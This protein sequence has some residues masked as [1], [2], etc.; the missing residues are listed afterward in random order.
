MH[1]VL[2]EAVSGLND[3]EI[4]RRVL[5]GET[6]LFELIV[7]RYNQRLFRTTRAILRD[8][9]A[10]EDAM[11]EAYLRAFA[12]L[13]QFAGEAKFS[14]WLTKIAVYEALGR[15]RKAKFEEE[16]DEAMDAE[17]NPERAAYGRELQSA[18]EQA[19]DSLPPMYRT[20]F[21]MR[22]VNELS[23]AETAD[24][25]GITQE[26]VKTRLHRA[27]TLL[28]KRLEQA[29][30][31]VSVHAFSYMGSRCDRMTAA[32]MRRINQLPEEVTSRQL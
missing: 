18:I 15:L 3:E 32:V 26:N 24:C 29:I 14:T 31:S 25:L 13:D 22:E 1:P 8:D 21:V 23:V 4:V 16:L 12:K 5:D 19:V 2:M 28:Q 10:A 11:Q 30:G 9:N 20:I 7:R 17:D 27:R 6:A